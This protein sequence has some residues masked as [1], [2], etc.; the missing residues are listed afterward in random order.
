MYNNYMKNYKIIS[1]IIIVILVGAV[2]WLFL[3]DKT[4]TTSELNININQNTA[5]STDLFETSTNGINKTFTSQAYNFTFTTDFDFSYF[6]N[7]LVDQELASYTLTRPN[8]NMGLDQQRDTLNKFNTAAEDRIMIE[9]FTNDKN[10]SITDSSAVTAW[11]RDAMPAAGISGDASAHV[12]AHETAIEAL[13]AD[14]IDSF[15][16]GLFFINDTYIVVVMS[17]DVP[18]DGLYAI[19]DTF[20]FTD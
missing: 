7:P 1:L 6:V 14:G 17:D 8:S 3:Q 15:G 5:I 13:L 2:L 11:Q 16:R 12:F 20:K 10:L 9:V 18:K 19:A 4:T